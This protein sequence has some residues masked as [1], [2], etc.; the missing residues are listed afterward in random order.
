MTIFNNESGICPECKSNNLKVDSEHAEIFCGSCGIV[1][2]D[3]LISVSNYALKRLIEEEFPFFSYETECCSNVMIG[4]YSKSICDVNEDEYS[5]LISNTSSKRN[6]F[7]PKFD[8]N[9]CDAWF[10]KGVALQE[11][12]KLEKAIESYNHALKIDQNYINAWFNKGYAFILLD[13]FTEAVKSYDQFLKIDSNYSMVWNNR[14]FALKKLDE[15]EEAIKSFNQAIERDSNNIYAWN[16]KGFTLIDM[17]RYADALEI[18]NQVL[19]IEPLNENGFSG[20]EEALDYLERNQESGLIQENT[21]IDEEDG[22]TKYIIEALKD[23]DK[24]VRKEAAETLGLIGDMDSVRYL[25]D[26]LD[27]PEPD[28]RYSTMKAIKEIYKVN[29]KE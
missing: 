14:G 17:G 6:N 8:P 26:V 20:R 11:R 13:R 21:N 28:V 18:F 12:G 5:F 24:N 9:D 4:G 22:I 19:K 2:E 7:E 25:K 1:I 27:D 10:N 15:E 29:K 3:D 16:N 23:P